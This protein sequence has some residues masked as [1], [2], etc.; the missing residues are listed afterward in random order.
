MR[1]ISRS[2][3]YA[4]ACALLTLATTS[5]A[6][7]QVVKGKFQVGV[8]GGWQNY[9]KSSALGNTPTGGLKATYFLNKNIGIGGQFMAG[10]PWTKGEFFPY[11]RYSFLSADETNDTT[12]L[13]TVNQRVTDMQYGAHLTLRHEFGRIAPFATAGIGRYK[14]FLDPEQNNGLR[15]LSGASYTLGGGAEL[16]VNNSSAI[17]FTLQDLVLSN[18]DRDRFCI[19]CAGAFALMRE[20]RY[21]NPTPTPV[22]KKTTTHNA[23]FTVSFSFV[24]GEKP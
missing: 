18:F 12:L 6:G 22:A 16:L 15:D 8:Q 19:N 14:Y 2:V 9:D 11:V 17:H 10:R 7:A 4:S 23:R 13:Y 5:P 20:D 1:R 24:P 21:P 3:L